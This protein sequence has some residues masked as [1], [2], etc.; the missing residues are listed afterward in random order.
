M[1]V[2]SLTS[3]KGRREHDAKRFWNV[4]TGLA[5]QLAWSPCY[6]FRCGVAPGDSLTEEHRMAAERREPLRI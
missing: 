3:S 5:K 4:L 1:A 2:Q 6:L